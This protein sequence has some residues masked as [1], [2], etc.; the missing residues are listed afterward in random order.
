MGIIRQRTY[1]R[2]NELDCDKGSSAKG[3]VQA[4]FW[5]LHQITEQNLSCFTLYSFKISFNRR[6][7]FE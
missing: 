2:N 4:T 3:K 5:P 1:K 6:G 7:E